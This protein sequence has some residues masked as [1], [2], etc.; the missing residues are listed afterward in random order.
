MFIA[1][2]FSVGLV[3]RPLV[4]VRTWA[5]SHGRSFCVHHRYENRR[6][7]FIPVIGPDQPVVSRSAVRQEQAS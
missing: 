2:M 7:A 4:M 3:R 6:A 5:E 1:I